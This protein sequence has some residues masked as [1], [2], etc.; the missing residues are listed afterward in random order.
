MSM[1][2]VPPRTRPELEEFLSS[3][4]KK[5]Q[6]EDV[7]LITGKR[8]RTPGL[9][10]EEVAAL[11]GV[12]VVWY[13]WL[14]QGREINVSTTFLD[15]LSNV[16]KLNKSEKQHLYLLA[17]QRPPYE[18]VQTTYYFPPLIKKLLDDLPARPSYILNLRWDVLAWNHAA[19]CLFHFSEHE[20][21]S[22]NLLWLLFMD[23]KVKSL[24]RPYQEQVTHMVN[25][26]RR[27]YAK[28]PKNNELLYLINKLKE[29]SNEFNELWRYYDINGPC[30]GVRDLF[31][32]EIGALRFE[33]Y[34]LIV[35]VHQNIRMV[36]Y[37]IKEEDRNETFNNW[38]MS[39]K[40]IL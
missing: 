26:F 4:R 2:R 36:Y 25:S 31:I 29:V 13:T 30:S 6:P 9:R 24:I 39:N 21:Q 23:D 27:D 40:Y 20:L 1:N 18:L 15:N 35:D 14:E 33:H 8:R 37:A 10:R 34:S 17:Q 22:R 3:R 19:D 5:I 11:A 32:D 7:G 16:L 38:L 12:G 28:A